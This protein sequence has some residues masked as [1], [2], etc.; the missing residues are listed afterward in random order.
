MAAFPLGL[1][2]RNNEEFSQ[3]RDLF[4]LII[5]ENGGNSMGRGGF[6]VETGWFFVEM[7]YLFVETV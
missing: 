5:T 1:D 3:Q 4:P 2:L 6:I 7:F